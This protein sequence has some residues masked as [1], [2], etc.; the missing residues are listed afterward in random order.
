M[1]GSYFSKDIRELFVLLGSHAVRYVIVGGEAVIYHGHARLTGDV[2]I[3]Y[4][5]T[6][7]NTKR[8]YDALIAFWKGSV[9]GI[10]SAGEFLSSGVIV[11][12]GAP[13][14][15]VDLLN[16]I[17][18]V[19]FEEAW[20]SR[21]KVEMESAGERTTLHYLGLAELIRNKRAAGR[22]KDLEDLKYLDAVK[23][24]PSKKS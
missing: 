24:S 6:Q 2:D 16:A 9:P 8:L 23:E 15:R 13:P 12:F 21:V 7:D 3:F 19:S 18:G 4:D 22:P 17:D 11:Q 1:K 10:G 5:R 20:A 14:N